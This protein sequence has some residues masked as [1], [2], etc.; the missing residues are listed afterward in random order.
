MKSSDDYRSIARIYDLVLNP[1][2][3]SIR[4]DICGLL[5]SQNVA[6]AV[7]LG[8]GT[9]RQCAFLH[10][11]GIRAYGVDRSP[12]ML[13]NAAIKTPEE[14]KYYREDLRATSFSDNFFDSAILSLV[15]HEHEKDIRNRIIREA[16][17]ITK[18]NGFL[19]ILDHGRIES[20][21]TQVMHYF[22]CVPERLAGKKHFRNYL[23]F[24]KNRG[25]QGLVESLPGLKVV[26]G[27][28]YLFGG[29]WL[30]LARVKK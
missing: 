13:Q 12:A 4:K 22:S 26:E 11:Q 27:R 30:C 15:L 28:K 6:R 1:F 21:A 9:G 29:L 18:A 16:L 17:R 8:C 23:L 10:K 2:L 3:D 7:D 25:L 19:T 20:M 14:I 5:L 24:M